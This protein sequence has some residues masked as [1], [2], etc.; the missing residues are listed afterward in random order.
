M[1]ALRTW[2]NFNTAP[3]LV[4]GGRCA[5]WDRFLAFFFTIPNRRRQ[6]A[7]VFSFIDVLRM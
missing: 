7:A 4:S 2:Q 3:Q 6:P 1:S 5:R